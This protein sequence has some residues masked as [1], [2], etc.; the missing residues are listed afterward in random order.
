[1]AEPANTHT[2]GAQ[3]IAEQVRTYDAFGAMTKWGSLGIAALLLL[4]VVW[5]CTS[6]GFLSGFV[7]AVVLLAVGIFFLR[8]KPVEDH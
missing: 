5:F 2:R 1:M 3:D 6:A 4:L 7:A 8:D